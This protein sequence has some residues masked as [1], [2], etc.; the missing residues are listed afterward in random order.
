MEQDAHGIKLCG[1]SANLTFFQRFDEISSIPSYHH[2]N[3]N[4]WV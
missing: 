1:A 4:D 3:I 2:E